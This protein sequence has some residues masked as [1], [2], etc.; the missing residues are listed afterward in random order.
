MHS[1]SIGRTLAIRWSVLRS[2][3]YVDPDEPESAVEALIAL[4]SQPGLRE[5]LIGRGQ[6]RA[7]AYAWPACVARLQQALEQH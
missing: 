2:T 4:Q 6:R 5:D 1:R 7:R 3:I